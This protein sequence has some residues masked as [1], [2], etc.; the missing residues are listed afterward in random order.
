MKTVFNCAN[1]KPLGEYYPQGGN[2]I[3]AAPGLYSFWWLGS[4]K[5]LMN[6]QCNV[7]LKGPGEKPIYLRYDD[8]FPA[9]L[10]HCPLYI[11]KSTNLKKRI[12]QH[13]LIKTKSRIY[14]KTKN[15]EKVK[16][17]TSSCQLRTGIEH[18]FPCEDE[19][20][21]LIMK[22]VGISFCE[23]PEARNVADRFY[24][25]DYAIGYYRPWFNLD[26]ER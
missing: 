25:E 14:P 21:S 13:I 18:I 1:I 10:P 19:P 9:E 7:T 17:K 6:A 23:L 20:L 2:L 12:S 24:L 4:R 3:M 16:P 26:S 22:N 15:F 5:L 11:G 8:W